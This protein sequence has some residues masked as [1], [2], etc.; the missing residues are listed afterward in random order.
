MKT[1]V[2]IDIHKSFCVASFI[3]E[4]GK[5]FDSAK[6][7]TTKESLIAFAKSK[8]HKNCRITFESTTNAWGIV[9]ILEPYV[10]DIT[11]SNPRQTKA[12]AAAKIKTDKVDAN[13]LAQLL[14]VDFL[15]AVWIPDRE[16]R[17]LRQRMGRR[18]SLVQQK[19]AV[20]NRMHSVFHQ[21]IIK[22]PFTKLFSKDG[23][24]W[25]KEIELSEW[26]RDAIDSDLRLLGNIE[27]ELELLDKKLTSLG[28]SEDRVKTLMTLP[29]VDVHTAITLIA[30][31]GN[32]ERFKSADKAA[33]YIGLVPSTKQSALKCYHGRITKQG[34]TNARWMMIQAAQHVQTHPGPIGNFYRKLRKKKNHNI[35]VVAVAR[36][37]VTYAWHMLTNN[38]PYRYAQPRCTEKKLARLRIMATGKRKK[39]GAVKGSEKHKNWGTGKRTRSERPINELYEREGLPEIS[40]FDELSPGEQ[41]HIK[42]NKLVGVVRLI[43]KRRIIEIK[44]PNKGN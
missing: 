35:T 7:E 5:E 2:G 16:T 10:Q 37:L 32:I 18:R 4:D 8:L 42:Q 31:F 38:E 24:E 17:N 20:K 15:P 14:R 9:D 19:T 41:R 11:V 39:G 22:P 29:G 33:A 13:V 26:A 1:Y 43:H 36:K 6:V 34:N 12:I 21:Q 28:Y 27:N 23:R 30:A 44:N 25:L 3:D 40:S